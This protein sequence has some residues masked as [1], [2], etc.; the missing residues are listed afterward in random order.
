MRLFIPALF[1]G[2]YFQCHSPNTANIAV[3]SV[4]TAVADP[5]STATP[6]TLTPSPTVQVPSHPPY[7]SVI[8]I[9]DTTSIEL[10]NLRLRG[11]DE[12]SRD[13]KEGIAK[14]K[15]WH[16]DTATI[17]RMLRNFVPID[18]TYLDLA[19]SNLE[20]AYRA[21]VKISGVHYF[22]EVN[23]GAYIELSTGDTTYLM[24]AH[25]HAF[26]KYFIELPGP[27]DN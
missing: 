25:G 7:D 9:T 15:N 16:L 1:I 2:C 8:R 24:A 19:F 5:V 12:D 14:C 20:C 18:G 11:L 22:L 17:V 21:D 27:G 3:D 13:G 6:A 26:D 10:N 4:T 23:G